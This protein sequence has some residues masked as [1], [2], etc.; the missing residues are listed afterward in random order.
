[1]WTS[2]NRGSYDRG[3]QAIQAAHINRLL[4]VCRQ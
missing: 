2:E 3:K 4:T 1:M